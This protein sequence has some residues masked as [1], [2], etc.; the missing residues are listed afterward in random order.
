MNLSHCLLRRQGMVGRIECYLQPA[1]SKTPLPPSLLMLQMPVPQF[2]QACFCS[3]EE[4]NGG[5]LFSAL[6]S[7]GSASLDALVV[8]MTC[9]Q[10]LGDVSLNIGESKTQSHLFHDDFR[11]VIDPVGMISA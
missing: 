11:I 10:L 4:A 3:L 5:Q 8:G 9:S 2:C 1:R 7:S 6:L